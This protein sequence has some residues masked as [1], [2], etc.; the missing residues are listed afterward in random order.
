[1]N[2][3]LTLA[4]AL[5]A[6]S[7]AFAGLDDGVFDTWLGSAGEPQVMTGLDNG[8]QTAGYW[9]SYGDG[10]DGGKSRVEWKVPPGNDYSA[11]A[12][13]PVVLACGGV[14][15]TAILDKGTLTY[16]PFVGIGF[17]VVGEGASGDPEPGDATA[18]GGVCITYSSAAAPTLELGLGSF[19]A[20]IGYANPAANLNK[21]AAGTSKVLAWS[22]FKQPSWYKGATKVSGAE[23]AKKLVAVKFK[24]QAATGN[25][26]FNICAIGPNARLPAT[27]FRVTVSSLSAQ[28]PLLRQSSLAA[29]SASLASSLPLLLKFSTSRVRLLQRVTLLAHS[30]SLTSTQAS[31]WFAL[32]AS[33]STSP[34]RSC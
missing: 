20:E 3:K 18:W 5:L 27:L 7:A 30:A 33:P 11:D 2:K 23:A 1:M 29:L 13:D 8:S 22:D 34:T 10:G 21:S 24:I 19:D 9:F 28:L 25:Y 32:L 17:N 14:C 16:Q 31:T 26:D 4:T 15:G 6:G 12:L